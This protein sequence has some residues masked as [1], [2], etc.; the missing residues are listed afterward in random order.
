MNEKKL[1]D[2]LDGTPLKFVT[3]EVF[4]PDAW[5]AREE[6]KMRNDKINLMLIAILII[7]IIAFYTC[8]G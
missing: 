4:D 7:L 8:K 2:D 3:T 1:W 5:E 6:R